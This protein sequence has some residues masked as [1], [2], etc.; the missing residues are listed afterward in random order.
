M[1]DDINIFEELILSGSL[2]AS[3]MDLETG[4][5]LYTFTDKLKDFSPGLH[6]EF[7]NYFYQ[8]MM[9]LWEL[10]FIDID[11]TEDDPHVR[12]TEKALNIEETKS[13]EKNTL[14]S[15]R[16]ILRILKEQQ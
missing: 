14:Y 11:L 12:I 10:G 5:M 2:E 8:E 1:S 9:S 13:L 15:L 3:G 6:K 4:E 7:S 16:E